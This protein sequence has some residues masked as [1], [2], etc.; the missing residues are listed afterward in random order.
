MAGENIK[1][2]QCPNCSGTVEIRNPGQSTSVV[3]INCASILDPTTNNGVGIIQYAHQKITISPEIPLGK[4]GEFFGKKWMVLGAMIRE[5]IKWHFSWVEYLL[6]NPTEGFAWLTQ[7]EGNW[8]F[9]RIL[10]RK[11]YKTYDSALFFRGHESLEHQGR[12]FRVFHRGKC[13]VK[14]CIGEFSWRV[15]VGDTVDFTDFVRSGEM[16]SKEVNDSE[17]IYS[18][19][20]YI[21]SEEVKKAFGLNKIS[22]PIKLAAYAPSSWEESW[23]SCST[24]YSKLILSLFLISMFFIVKA[25][26]DLLLRKNITFSPMLNNSKIGDFSL[27]KTQNLEFVLDAPLDNNWFEITYTLVNKN[28]GDSMDIDQGVEYYHGVDSDGSWSEGS[29]KGSKIASSI[30]PGNY[31]LLIQQGT[32]PSVSSYQVNVTRDVP[33]YSNLIL[34]FLLLSAYPILILIFYYFETKNRWSESDYT[35]FPIPEDE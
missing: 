10:K 24:I 33:V 22:S 1:S 25:D 9:V 7:S 32:S 15:K 6:F 34:A 20:L 31:E 30:P 8:A 19:G 27:E 21:D 13:A 5:D 14:L 35:P 16:I 2:L 12:N 3:C 11:P 17:I 23:N 4:K 29:R 26:S 28:T 18:H